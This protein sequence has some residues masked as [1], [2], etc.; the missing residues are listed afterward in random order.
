MSLKQRFLAFAKD[1]NDDL[2]RCGFPLCKGNIM[3]S[4]P[5]WCLPDESGWNSSATGFASPT[6]SAAQRHHFLRFRPHS[7][8]ADLA[9][10]MRRH[11]LGQTAVTVFCGPW[12]RTP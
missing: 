8:K 6:R 5:Q 11:L 7:A 10:Q 3:A 12:R 1:V 9:D 2:D 4:N